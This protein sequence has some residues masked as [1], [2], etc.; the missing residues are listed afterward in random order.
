MPCISGAFPHGYDSSIARARKAQCSTARRDAPIDDDALSV[1]G[2]LDGDQSEALREP[3]GGARL[4]STD[5]GALGDP[6]N[7]QG[8]FPGRLSFV[9]NDRKHGQRVCVQMLSHTRRND[10]SRCKKPTAPHN[11]SDGG[12]ALFHCGRTVFRAD[13]GVVQF[14]SVSGGRPSW[15]AVLGRALLFCFAV[16]PQLGDKCKPIS[17][18]ECRVVH[19]NKFSPP[20]TEMGHFRTIRPVS[21]AGRCPLRPESGPEVGRDRQKAQ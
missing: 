11:S 8:A 19:H 6:C 2:F 17:S 20:M 3:D 16:N 9:S 14:Q 1:G 10:N 15:R 5:V 7:R 18:S 13:D 4:G 21:P 12:L